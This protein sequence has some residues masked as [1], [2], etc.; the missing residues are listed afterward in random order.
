MAA[1]LPQDVLEIVFR[2]VEQDPH[3]IGRG[4]KKL[5][6]REAGSLPFAPP[7]L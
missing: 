4:G 6:K 3:Q 5:S 2:Y 7:Q 1:T